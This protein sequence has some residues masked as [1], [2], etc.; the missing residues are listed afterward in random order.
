MTE[1]EL[2]KL[3]LKYRDAG[4]KDMMVQ[5]QKEYAKDSSADES[6]IE[7]KAL[8]SLGRYEGLK[9]VKD[10][11]TVSPL[12]YAFNE[13]ESGLRNLVDPNSPSNWTNMSSKALLAA[14]IAGGYVKDVPDFAPEWKKQ[15]KRE[16]FGKFLNMLARE[17][18]DQG[19]R[20]AVSEY[21]NT[22]FMKDP[23]GWA[24]KGINDVLFRTYSKRAKEQ[25]L[26]GEGFSGSSN[27]LKLDIL[28]MPAGD[29]ATLGLDTFANAAYGAGAAGLS[30]AIAGNG[31]RTAGAIY[32]SDLGAGVLGGTA[33]VLNRA[34]NTRAGVMPY[35]YITEPAVG[36]IA[37]AL[38]SPGAVRSMVSGGLSFMRGGRVGDMS[39][40]N[41]M[42]RAGDWVASK[43]GWDEA[44]LARTFR[45]NGIAPDPS[46]K[47]W[48]SD[49]KKKV[50]EMKEIWDDGLTDSPGETHSLFDE[51]QYMYEKLQRVPEELGAELEEGM[52]YQDVQP[53]TQQ[54]DTLLKNYI[55]QLKGKLAN[56]AGAEEAPEIQRQ[57]KYFEN[58]RDIFANGLMNPHDALTQLHPYKMGTDFMRE[59]FTPGKPKADE[60][61]VRKADDIRDMELMEDYVNN[62]I[63]GD[64]LDGF[65]SDLGDRLSSLRDEFPEFD[66]YVSGL[67]TVRVPGYESKTG[68]YR[69][70][71]VAYGNTVSYEGTPHNRAF[72]PTA[73]VLKAAFNPRIAGTKEAAKQVASTLSDAVLTGIARPV[74]TVEGKGRFEHDD[75]S[76]EAIQRK[77][78]EL[79]S[80]K[81]AA[82]EAA[83]NWK[84]DPRLAEK[85]QLNSEERNLVNQ[86]RAAKLD[87]AMNG[88]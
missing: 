33:D 80:R 60:F 11:T 54:F 25:A 61:K 65:D 79:K 24:Q 82:A 76:F 51:L 7:K 52:T 9:A 41:M 19:R 71:D 20:N 59:P 83:L 50:Q 56:S 78:E 40:R 3:Y 81:P 53:S 17:S 85:D 34:F 35:E 32:G 66:K 16:Q 37:N 87:E 31:L 21:E 67:R 23:I 74:L 55:E 70:G 29:L 27:P 39:K 4:D 73:E 47:W 8:A 2:E 13:S 48:S 26:N 10:A 62:S 75:N 18:F 57:I 86:Y 12:T 42:K 6:V 44:E 45:D 46:N 64:A 49:T 84:Y 38:M 28:K 72:V 77:F 5:V 36:G 88:R 1:K 58:A 69:S 63:R 30:R 43:T 68:Y 15:E 22:T 14:A